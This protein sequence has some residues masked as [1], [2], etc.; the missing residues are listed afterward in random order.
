M[1]APLGAEV[2][3][4]YVTDGI[5]SSGPHNPK[6]ADARAWAGWVENLVTS[7]VLSSGPWFS[8]KAAMTLGYAANTIA[9]VYNDPIA[10]NNGLYIKVGASSSGAWT[11]LTSFLPGY[12]FVK[13]SPTG[14]STANAIVASTSPR[15]PSGD[16]V[17]LVTLTVPHT[18]TSTPVTVS[19]DG[20]PVLTI[21]TR[22]G[23]DP[24]AGEMQQNDVVAGFV[25]GATFRLISDLNSLR[26]AQSAK[27]WANNDE[28]VPVPAN[29]GGNGI[30]T[31]SAKHWAAKSEE[32]ANRSEDARDQA[33]GYVNDIVA[34]KEVPIFGTVEGLSLLNIPP[35]MTVISTSGFD[36]VDDGNGWPYIVEVTEDGSAL[37]PWQRQ[38]NLGLRRWELRVDEVTPGMFGDVAVDG[39]AAL[40]AAFNYGAVVNITSEIKCKSMVIALNAVRINGNGWRGKLTW[41]ADATSVG[42]KVILPANAGTAFIKDV[43]FQREGVDGTALTVDG[44]AQIRYDIAGW[45]AGIIMPRP[46]GKRLEIRGCRFAGVTEGAQYFDKAVSLISVRDYDLDGNYVTGGFA[47]GVPL[48]TCGFEMDNTGEADGA[49]INANRIFYVQYAIRWTGGEGFFITN[50]DMQAI[51]YGV[52]A[53]TPDR[54][55]NQV[56]LS[57]NHISATKTAVYL[58]NY[59]YN[60]LIG[61]EFHATSHSTGED[62]QLVILKDCR[63]T[64]VLGNTLRSGSGNPDPVDGLIFQKSA[65]TNGSWW[66]DVD[67]NVFDYLRQPITVPAGL[68]SYFISPRNLYGNWGPGT[69]PVLDL[70][71]NPRP[72]AYTENGRAPFLNQGVQLQ[73]G[74]GS[75]PS[76]AINRDTSDGAAMLIGRQG[77]QVGSIS[78][79]ASGTTFNTTSDARLKLKEADLAPEKAMKIIKL[80]SVYEFIWNSTGERDIG[81]FAQELASVYPQAC[82][83]GNGEPG[84]DTFIPWGVDW[85]RLIPVVV[86]AVQGLENRVSALED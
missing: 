11:Q 56:R 44:S 35:G 13:A 3:R 38:S 86:A 60:K 4:D 67:D 73:T 20:A 18:S 78:V 21:K 71:R 62:K 40:I 26:N 39:T 68:D 63:N 55:R 25:S 33:A 84:D 42:L 83:P 48:A 47:A 28:D 69:D 15:L 66:C 12:Q 30:T 2:W 80:I 16:G 41:T 1:N 51:K 85:S 61:N 8:T 36:A 29:L 52:Y 10:A 17:A 65:G 72:M 75:G 46:G 5:P 53:T 24:D 79:T 7:G 22:T 23:E 54:I 6:K 14:E 50:N 59:W 34:E 58:E 57:N 43:V 76:F 31:F 81:S 19:F 45:P 70:S 32:D 49:W 27:A 82:T 9:I 77:A 37:L 64:S 74:R